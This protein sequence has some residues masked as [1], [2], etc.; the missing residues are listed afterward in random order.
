MVVFSGMYL[1]GVAGLDLSVIPARRSGVVRSATARRVACTGAPAEAPATLELCA[2]SLG[3]LGSLVVM[4]AV[5]KLLMDACGCRP[6]VRVADDDGVGDCV[7]HDAGLQSRSRL[8]LVASDV[9]KVVDSRTF[10][11]RYFNLF[12]RKGNYVYKSLL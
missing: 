1:S 8:R 3:G 11:N 12:S 2:A 10:V 5:G 7:G 4:A 9:S 6:R